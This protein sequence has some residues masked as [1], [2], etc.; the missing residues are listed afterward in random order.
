MPPAFFVALPG[1]E[2]TAPSRRRTRG[3]VRH[4]QEES[5]GEAREGAGGCGLHVPGGESFP[6]RSGPEM[7]E[8]E[9]KQSLGRVTAA[10]R[11]VGPL[12]VVLEAWKEHRRAASPPEDLR[13]G[14]LAG[15]GRQRK[16]GRMTRPAL[17]LVRRWPEDGPAERAA[18]EIAPLRS[19]RAGRRAGKEELPDRSSIPGVTTEPGPCIGLPSG[20][21][22][23]AQRSAVFSSPWSTMRVI[24]DG[25]P[26]RQ[27][28]PFH[29]PV[30]GLT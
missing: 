20:K 27:E 25:T 26:R 8:R 23:D 5:C 14:C 1:R 11:G 7:F 28:K 13:S 10:G 30:P 2:G 22:G 18:S 17:T 3:I 12:V 24:S 29:R 19:W 6:V 15:S 4:F 9:K 16:H 21:N